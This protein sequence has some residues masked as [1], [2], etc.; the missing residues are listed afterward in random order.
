MRVPSP[1]FRHPFHCG[2]RPTCRGERGLRGSPGGSQG[3]CEC[4]LRA[5][6]EA[7][8]CW[9]GKPQTS[10]GME[11][12][13]NT[14]ESE[15][16]LRYLW[17]AGEEGDWY[18][19]QMRLVLVF[20]LLLFL[21]WLTCLLASYFPVLGIQSL[22]LWTSAEC[23]V[24]SRGC[25][26]PFQVGLGDWFHRQRFAQRGTPLCKRGERGQPSLCHFFLQYLKLCLHLTSK[27]SNTCGGP[28][29]FSE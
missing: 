16:L 18:G 19:S 7:G 8:V 26:W 1:R 4:V 25:G 6:R 22:K 12:V 11:L 13:L 20:V 3:G 27:F 29:S 21:L 2:L 10:I 14:A 24:T 5:N 28:T 15:M 9:Q 17:E 23:T